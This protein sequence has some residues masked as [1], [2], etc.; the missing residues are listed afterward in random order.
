MPRGIRALLQ[1]TAKK[2]SK[3]SCRQ[4]DQPCEAKDNGEETR[5]SLY[6]YFHVE[7]CETARR[8][9]SLQPTSLNLLVLICMLVPE[10]LHRL[11]VCPSVGMLSDLVL[12]SYNHSAPCIAIRL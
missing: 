12:V 1:D 9:C 7:E 11:S 3:Q 6:K 4:R 5:L 10:L 2:L 8:R